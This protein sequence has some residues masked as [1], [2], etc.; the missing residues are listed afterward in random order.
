ML[1]Q[2]RKPFISQRLEHGLYRYR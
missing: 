2:P 1:F